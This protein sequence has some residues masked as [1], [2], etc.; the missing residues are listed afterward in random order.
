M[1]TQACR[2]VPEKTHSNGGGH[3]SQGSPP[4]DSD[5]IRRRWVVP[6]TKYQVPGTVCTSISRCSNHSRSSI[7][8]IVQ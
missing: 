4:R 2:L 3:V 7:I 5:N 6:N 1:P 8:I